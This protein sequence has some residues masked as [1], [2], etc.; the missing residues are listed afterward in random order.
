MVKKSLIR[1]H[2]ETPSL[3]GEKGGVR[4]INIENPKFSDPYHSRP[5]SPRRGESEGSRNE[6]NY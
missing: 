1:F 2:S 5:N 3:L 4:E 6:T